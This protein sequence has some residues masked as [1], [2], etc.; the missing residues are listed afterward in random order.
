MLDALKK[1][2]ETTPPD[3]VQ[4]VWDS[5]EQNNTVES[6]TVGDFITYHHIHEYEWDSPGHLENLF[7]NIENPRFTSDFLFYSNGQSC[8]FNSRLLV[9][10]CSSEHGQTW[11]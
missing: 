5:I 11:R 10:K 8:I 1:Y 4:K 6:P 3:E 2:F 9:Q 7:T